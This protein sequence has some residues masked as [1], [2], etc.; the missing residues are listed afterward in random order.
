MEQTWASCYALLVRPSIHAAAN[1]VAWAVLIGLICVSFVMV[2][3]LGPFGLILFGLLTLF[4]CTSVALRETMP[5]G[6]VAVPEAR[7]A[8]ERTPEQRAAMAEDRAGMDAPLRFCRW[9]GVVLL[10]AGVA[11]FAWQRLQ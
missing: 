5:I 9:C 11:G 7:T 6:S 4:V 1:A 3:I 8:R 10:V 2:V